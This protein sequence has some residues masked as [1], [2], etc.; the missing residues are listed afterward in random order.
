METDFK[1]GEV[2]FYVPEQFINV[3][4]FCFILLNNF[5]H[6][7]YSSKLMWKSFLC[8]V[9]GSFFAYKHQSIP[10]SSF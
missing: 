9:V 10:N 5:F 1:K 8:S 2:K 3:F 7:Y 4:K 6:L